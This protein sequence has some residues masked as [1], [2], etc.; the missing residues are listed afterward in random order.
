MDLQILSLK[1]NL[2]HF[3]AYMQISMLQ[4][5]LMYTFWSSS[6]KVKFETNIADQHLKT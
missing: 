6:N 1:G 3:E 4:K 5:F 2:Q